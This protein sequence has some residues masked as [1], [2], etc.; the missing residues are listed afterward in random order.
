MRMRINEVHAL[1]NAHHCNTKMAQKIP[2]LVLKLQ[3]MAKPS[4]VNGYWRKGTLSAR[5]LADIRKSLVAE[6]VYWP[7][8]LLRNRGSDK[9]FKLTKHE[10]TRAERYR[11]AV[12]DHFVATV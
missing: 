7:Q 1:I 5:K 9:P 4:F 6:G 12:S 10:R 2:E 11:E 8:K 3:Q